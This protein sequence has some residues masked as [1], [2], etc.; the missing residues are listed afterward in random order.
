[1]FG[2][3]RTIVA[4][5]S[6]LLAPSSHA[7]TRHL[8]IACV[9]CK[10]VADRH[11]GLLICLSYPQFRYDTSSCPFSDVGIDSTGPLTVK[12]CAGIHVKAYICLHM[13]CYPVY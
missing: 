9:T 11:H 1:M 2:I 7:E 5:P 10:I 3:G 12:D 6:Q 13:S 8:L 4:F